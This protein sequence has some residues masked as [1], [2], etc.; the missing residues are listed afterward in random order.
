MAPTHL[1]VGRGDPSASAARPPITYLLAEVIPVPLPHGLRR[2]YLLAEVIPVPLPHGPRLTYL[3]A[4][5]IPVPL[6][7]GVA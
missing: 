2:T 7:H 6:P 5:M 1:F 4:E 3:L